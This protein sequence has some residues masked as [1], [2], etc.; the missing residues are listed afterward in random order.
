MLYSS[1]Q[2]RG[3]FIVRIIPKWVIDAYPWVADAISVLTYLQEFWHQYQNLIVLIG[4]FVVARRL[5]QE[6]IKLSERVDTLGQIVRATR[7]Q[8]EAALAQPQTA[9]SRSDVAGAPMQDAASPANWE[10]VRDIWR[11]ARDRIELAIEGITRS[12]VRAK[13]SKLPRY[14]YRDVVN[15]LETDGVIARAVSDKLRGMDT[16]FN[17]YK[18]RPKSVTSAEVAAFKQLF[19]L[20]D[21][22]LP[23]LPKDETPQE[24]PA[25]S[26][27]QLQMGAPQAA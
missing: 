16:A 20:P 11:N 22:R 6:R 9:Q 12:R 15:A 18:F 26:P 17:T 3:R 2:L 14:T 8:A 23:K 24:P 13:Y 10:T 21:S 25:A 7:D 5:R 27:E 1:F 4:L 19:E